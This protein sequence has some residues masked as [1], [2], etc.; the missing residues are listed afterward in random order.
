MT[1]RRAAAAS[2]TELYG[3]S[4]LRILERVKLEDIASIFGSFVSKFFKE[5]GFVLCG[6][7]DRRRE[8]GDLYCRF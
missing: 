7:E 5:R 8:C 3:S 6:G 1:A 4:V 2:M